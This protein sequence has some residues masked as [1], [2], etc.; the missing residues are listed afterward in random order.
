MDPNLETAAGEYEYPVIQ[1]SGDILETVP[2]WEGVELIF[3]PVM[4]MDMPMEFTPID[5]SFA[6]DWVRAELSLTKAWVDAQHAAFH[7]E[8]GELRSLDEIPVL[9]DEDYFEAVLKHF[10]AFGDVPGAVQRLTALIV[11]VSQRYL[12]MKREEAHTPVPPMPRGLIDHVK[13]SIAER[14]GAS[15]KAM[16]ELAQEQFARE[17]LGAIAI[18]LLKSDRGTRVALRFIRQDEAMRLAEKLLLSR[19]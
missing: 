8:D 17:L 9:N 4:G 2:E 13:M 18:D 11:Q 6:P 15:S 1:E 16:H 12:E 14:V 7:D 5:L 3:A 10:K 19:S